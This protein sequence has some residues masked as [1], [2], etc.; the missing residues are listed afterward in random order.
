VDD[1]NRTELNFTF[2]SP[3]TAPQNFR[4]QVEQLGVFIQSSYKFDWGSTA[5]LN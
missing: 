1:A 5:A 3:P 2:P 4:A